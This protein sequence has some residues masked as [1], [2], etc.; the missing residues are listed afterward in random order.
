MAAGLVL[1]TT[2][3]RCPFA[4]PPFVAMGLVVLVTYLV[5]FDRQPLPHGCFGAIALHEVANPYRTRQAIVVILLAI[6]FARRRP[7]RDRLLRTLIQ[8][9]ATA[10]MVS[11]LFMLIVTPCEQLP[12]C[13]MAYG[14][15]AVLALGVLA[16]RRL[17]TSPLPNAVVRQPD[18]GLFA[19]LRS[20]ARRSTGQSSGEIRRARP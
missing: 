18:T 8:T 5:S 14:A 3:F 11:T 1:L 10:A 19:R 4:R 15:S 20:P 16:S 2:V 6:A 13:G 12:F 7:V 17:A 9:S